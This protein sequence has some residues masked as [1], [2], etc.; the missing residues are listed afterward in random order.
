MILVIRSP[1]FSVFGEMAMVSN[2][3]KVYK[4]AHVLTNPMVE[5]PS[6]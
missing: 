1:V 5:E 6:T 4:V 2:H 3:F